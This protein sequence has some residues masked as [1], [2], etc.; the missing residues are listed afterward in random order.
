MS[1]KQIL[2]DKSPQKLDRSSNNWG[3]FMYEENIYLGI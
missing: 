2:I 3:D 1:K